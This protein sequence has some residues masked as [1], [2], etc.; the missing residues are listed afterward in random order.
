VIPLVPIVSLDDLPDLPDLLTIDGRS[1]ST[2]ALC[3]GVTSLASDLSGVSSVAVLAT[4]SLETI[5]AVLAGLVAGVTVVP[6][7]A[8]SGPMEERH[9]LS[10]SGASIRLG[11]GELAGSSSRRGTPE[12]VTRPSHDALPTSFIRDPAEEGV[13]PE[14]APALVMYTSGTT[15][16]AKGVPIRAEA[17]AAD[18]DALAD[19]W[20]WTPDDVLVHGLPL[21]HVHGLVLGILGPLRLGCRLI[22]TGRPTPEGYGAAASRGGTLYFGVPTVWSRIAAV[23]GAAQAMA[24][25]RLLV[26]G[27][28]AL[29]ARVAASLA[30]SCGQAPIE[31]Y[32]MTETLITL[33][34]RADGERRAGWVGLRL[35]GVE[36]RLVDDDGRSIDHDGATVGALEVRGDTVM[37]GYL[38]RVD[39]DGEVFGPDG[40][41]RT[42]DAGVIDD[43]GHHRIIG[44]MA[45]DFIKSGGYRIGAG[46]VESVLLAHGAVREAAVIG[47]PDDDLGQAIVAYVVADGVTESQLVELVAEQLARHKR[48]RRVVFVAELPRNSMGKVRKDLLG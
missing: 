16:P 21:S 15:G 2:D 22:H 18:I 13:P 33:S 11:F 35:P 31:R 32:G 20:Q 25:A 38:N 1:V 23:E 4:T 5:V 39:A 24:K 43:G 40:W 17:I 45:S 28:A 19:A 9:M 37:S 46:E 3:A 47:V 36:T 41:F 30:A 12:V 6:V 34:Q 14:T 48:P 10:D 26:S 29:P 27:S 7:P 8:D 44:R 42:G